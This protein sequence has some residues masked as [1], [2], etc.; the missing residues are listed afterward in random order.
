M[1]TSKVVSDE[2][3]ANCTD[4]VDDCDTYNYYRLC[5]TS[6]DRPFAMVSCRKHCGLCKECAI[7]FSRPQNAKM[8][9]SL[10][11]NQF[12]L[13]YNCNDGYSL[14]NG[15]L[16]RTCNNSTWSGSIPNC[17]PDCKDINLVPINNTKEKTADGN[18]YG[19]KATVTCKEGYVV[20]QNYNQTAFNMSCSS[21]GVWQNK[22]DCVPVD[23]ANVT[24]LKAH[25]IQSIAYLPNTKF[26]SIA[27]ATCEVGH[28]VPGGNNRQNQF[29]T[30]CASDGS[31]K[32]VTSCV[33]IDCGKIILSNIPNAKEIY[34]QN[35]TKYESSANISCDEG[36][37]VANQTQTKDISSTVVKCKENGKWE[38]LP[39]CLKKD[40]GDIHILSIE[41]AAVRRNVNGNK[42]GAVAQIDCDVGYYHRNQTKEI[43]TTKITC[44]ETG[45]WTDIPTC[46][47]KDCKNIAN[48]G[49]NYINLPARLDKD[50]MYNSTADVDCK[51]GYY[52]KKQNQTTGIST[53]T[54]FCSDKGTWINMPTCKL[55]DCGP[56]EDLTISNAG[57]RLLFSGSN[58][59]S[60]A[61]ITCDKGYYDLNKYNQPEGTSTTMITCSVNGIWTGLPICA[62]KDCGDVNALYIDHAANRRQNNGTKYTSTADIDCN[63]G[64]YIK[65]Q[66]QWIGIST[67]TI[68]CSGTG[69]W[70]DVPICIPKD[71]GRLDQLNLSNAKDR[72]LIN[73]TTIYTSLANISCDDGYKELISSQVLG[74]TSTVV[75]CN[76]NGT[77][78][79]LPKCVRK[80][81]GDVQNVRIEHAAN[82]T[83][84]NK[85]TKYNDTAEVTCDLGYYVTDQY[86]TTGVSKRTLLCSYTGQWTNIPKCIPK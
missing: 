67:R 34:F 63:E 22:L 24:Q 68:T 4:T 8:T 33:R 31:W 36:F 32:N 61:A 55:K 47:R 56:L 45:E 10:E 23:C 30:T 74:I 26:M 29:N 76:E 80:D 46:R 1:S 48:L 13:S 15:S 44:S 86:Q 41:N 54:M 20:S 65:G 77:W 3:E 9:L 38:K 5:N 35:D 17:L 2:D 42:F 51:E 59:G 7:P 28:V 78:E 75:R 71:C 66:P 82:R 27:T 53:T 57:L 49:L 70:T 62:G 64:Y 39:T 58:Y 72:S 79:N 18:R 11:G 50:T 12:K 37:T 43:S 16:T 83:L 6:S 52:N 14:I 25:Y 69:M 40:C 81:C 19:S 21:D 84:L 73:G 60:I 85:N